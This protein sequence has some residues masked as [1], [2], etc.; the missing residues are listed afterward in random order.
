MN[1]D[2][3]EECVRR[4]HEITKVDFDVVSN[5]IQDY[6]KILDNPEYIKRVK[7]QHHVLCLLAVNKDG[8]LLRYIKKE[9][10]TRDVV[11]AAVTQNW[12]AINFVDLT[13]GNNNNDNNDNNNDNNKL[14]LTNLI[15]INWRTFPVILKKYKH[16]LTHDVLKECVSANGNLI[17][18]LAQSNLLTHELVLAGVKKDGRALVFVP[19]EFLTPDVLLA[20]VKS[21]PRALECVPEDLL[22]SKLIFEAVKRNSATLHYVPEEKRSLFTPEI[23]DVAMQSDPKTIKYFSTHPTGT[24]TGA[25]TGTGTRTGKSTSEFSLE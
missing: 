25:G 9:Y 1:A 17:K 3:I 14:L 10:L 18:F 12:N 13:S 11:I 19:D 7:V 23:M 24:L 5:T 2:A 20:A 21:D 6:L 4:T 22:T 16:L 15:K 8:M